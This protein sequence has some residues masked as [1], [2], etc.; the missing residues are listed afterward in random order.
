MVLPVTLAS[1]FG[2]LIVGAKA[3]QKPLQRMVGF[4]ERQIFLPTPSGGFITIQR[5]VFESPLERINNQ[6]AQ[7]HS[8][9]IR[10]SIS[11][12]SPLVRIFNMIE[13]LFRT[14]FLP[15]ELFISS[16]LLPILPL[17]RLGI[18]FMF[19]VVMP[20]AV[21]FF[22][23][24]SQ[25]SSAF[26]N[27]LNALNFIA[28]FFGFGG[29]QEEGEGGEKKEK[30][31]WDQIVEWV[32]NLLGIGVA[33]ATSEG[34]PTEQTQDTQARDKIKNPITEF[35]DKIYDAI[36]KHPIAT[37]IY[38]IVVTKMLLPIMNFINKFE[39]VFNMHPIATQIQQI[40]ITKVFLPVFNF[41]NKI[42]SEFHTHP[43]ALQ[44]QQVVINKVFL[45]VFNF[46]NKFES[47]FYTHPVATNIF[48]IAMM[49]M[50]IP[51]VKFMDK[52]ESLFNWHPV[53][54]NIFYIAMMKMLI[55][56]VQFMDKFESVFYTHPVVIGIS[57]LIQQNVINPIVELIAKIASKFNEINSTIPTKINEINTA[58]N[59]L[60]DNIKSRIS[61][62]ASSVSIGGGGGGR[63]SIVRS[64]G[65]AT[66]NTAWLG[67]RPIAPA[68]AYQHG[69][70]LF[71][72][73]FGIG[74]M[75]GRRYTFAEKQPELVTPIERTNVG[76]NGVVINVTINGNIIGINDFENR[77]K[78]IVE[79]E[80][81]RVK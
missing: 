11:P 14:L 41:L 19:T 27:A 33:E 39:F 79:T 45:P 9:I 15:L 7:I 35:F 50:L 58:I 4:G 23:F 38:E 63:T 53:A 2:K 59:N 49:K 51:V 26:E 54:T 67:G 42:E 29:Q 13:R 57:Q 20:Y 81:R 60:I 30:T 8:S 28:S 76:A 70:L 74:L 48:Y 21:K 22:M 24:M 55:P 37:Q 78:Q 73:V 44:I 77:I 66:V 5:R 47:L 65:V 56:V 32:M 80:L 17:L 1:I 46:L 34:L 75:T 18:R 25:V 6:L 3:L 43:I 68:Y 10:S 31:L 12:N 64:G 72:P 62:L 69:G 61:A 52:F 36:T 71:E 16:L 40:V